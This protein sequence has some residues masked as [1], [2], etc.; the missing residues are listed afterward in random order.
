VKLHLKGT[1]F[2]R[3]QRFTWLEGGDLLDNESIDGVSTYE[4]G[5]PF[6][7]DNYNLGHNA[8]GYLGMR[9]GNR[10]ETANSKFTSIFYIISRR[11]TQF[12]NLNQVFGRILFE[13]ERNWVRN[14]TRFLGSETG[15][16]LHIRNGIIT[17]LP[18]ITITDSG[19]LPLD[20]NE[21]W[22][23]NP[24]LHKKEDL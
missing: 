5:L 15:E 21:N 23:L 7:G 3:C 14:H 20:G 13:E 10:T 18:D 6:F 22:I 19:E 24:D 16:R 2:S 9:M 12:D 4:D 8:L 1:K 11:I 17:Q